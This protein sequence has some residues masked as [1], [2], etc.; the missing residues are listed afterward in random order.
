MAIQSSINKIIGTAATAATIA[1]KLG[2]E[3]EPKAPK[4]EV[5]NTS[6]KDAKMAAKARKVAQQ[7]IK[8]II[9]NKEI[10]EK[11]R[12]RRIGKVLDEFTGGNK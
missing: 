7:K 11:A 9:N 1:S 8:T 10:S 4:E 6:G 3:K 5:K 2:N 12:S